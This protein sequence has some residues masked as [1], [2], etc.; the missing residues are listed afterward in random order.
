M[1]AMMHPMFQGM[2][3]PKGRGPQP[4]DKWANVPPNNTVYVNNLNEKISRGEL[5]DGLRE[6]FGQFGKVLD[7]TCYTK[8]KRCKGQAWVVME[9]TESASN[10]VAEMQNFIFFNKPLRVAFSKNVSDATLKRD[11]KELPKRERPP[12]K[13]KLK[14]KVVVE[15]PKKKKRKKSKDK[16]KRAEDAEAE[17]K[18]VAEN[19]GPTHKEHRDSNPNGR[20]KVIKRKNMAPPN[21]MLFLQ[22]LPKDAATEEVQA[23]FMA[24]PGLRA[25]NLIEN[26][27]GIGFV[28]FDDHYNS[29][30]AQRSLNGFNLRGLEM[31]V[32][33]AQ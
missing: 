8:I 3:F 9:E 15:E 2:K 16:A 26:K 19:G 1:P 18:E 25:V 24:F 4:L 23:L 30:N 20:P 29:A 14:K 27:P 17:K 21:K 31:V 5:V 28:E 11:G 32:E 7:I 13:R 6:V 33:F 22:N 12:K 10:A